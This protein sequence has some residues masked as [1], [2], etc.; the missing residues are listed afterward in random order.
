MEFVE[1]E[2]YQLT[3]GVNNSKLVELNSTHAVIAFKNSDTYGELKTIRMDGTDIVEVMDSLVHHSALASSNTLLKFNYTGGK[4][5]I[6]LAFRDEDNDGRIKTFSIDDS[7]YAITEISEVEHETDYCTYPS[8]GLIDSTHVVLGYTGTDFDGFV[9]VFTID[10]SFA[11]SQTTVLEYA[12][13]ESIY[14]VTLTMLDSTHFIIVDM[15]TDNHCWLRTFSI[16]A[17]TYVVT[18]ERSL[19]LIAGTG[20]REFDMLKIDSTHCILALTTGSSS[21]RVYTILIAGDY[22]PSAI[23]YA[24]YDAAGHNTAN[25]SLVLYSAGVYIL[26]VR[27][28]SAAGELWSF[29]VDGSFNITEGAFLE[30]DAAVASYTYNSLILIGGAILLAYADGDTTLQLKTFTYV[31]VIS[32]DGTLTGAGD[33]EADTLVT[34]FITCALSGLGALSADTLI[35]SIRLFIKEPK[36]KKQGLIATHVIVRS[37]TN[38]ATAN[39]TPEPGIATKI[40]RLIKI[41]EGDETA[42]QEVADELVAKWGREQISVSGPVDLTVTLLF[43]QKVLVIVDKANIDTNMILQKKVHNILDASTTVVCGDIILSDDEL[44]ARILE[45]IES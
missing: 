41:P 32:A 6:V 25:P 10:G 36:V 2:K 29:D 4:Y 20:A 40:E 33:I 17:G 7:T 16:N 15:E 38:E 1:Q 30:H 18:A 13:A 12:P 11:I 14:F 24:I 37:P 26:A 3:S 19:E 28:A 44:I 43:R 31:N 9:K 5:Y 8:L 35:L 45:G 27:N 22:T 39:I 21:G 23:D 42:C 34:K